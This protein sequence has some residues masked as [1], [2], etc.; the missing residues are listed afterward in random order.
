MGTESSEHAP[1]I[2]TRRTHAIAIAIGALRLFMMVATPRTGTAL[3][4]VAGLAG[5]SAGA[6]FFGYLFVGLSVILV[7]FLRREPVL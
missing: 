2:F 3:E 5:A 7:R 1:P 6:L 4:S